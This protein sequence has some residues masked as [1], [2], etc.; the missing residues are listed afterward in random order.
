MRG[1]GRL[2]GET[3]VCLY[4]CGSHVCLLNGDF[5][6]F[7]MRERD[8]ADVETLTAQ[9][10]GMRARDAGSCS[11]CFSYQ[12]VSS[13]PWLPQPRLTWEV[14]SAQSGGWKGGLER[15]GEDGQHRGAAGVER[16][17]AREKEEE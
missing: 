3:S 1:A 5:K 7:N 4:M 9:E 6:N 17:L 11:V 12:Q 14:G 2:L 15:M 13:P 8:L 16:N 10:G